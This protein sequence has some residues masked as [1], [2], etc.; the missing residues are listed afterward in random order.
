MGSGFL[1]EMVSAR[2]AAASGWGKLASHQLRRHKRPMRYLIPVSILLVAGCAPTPAPTPSKPATS[3]PLLSNEHEH[4][5]LKGMTAVDLAEHLGT[6]RIQIR[7]GDG[8]KLQFVGATCILDA[9]LYPP[10]EG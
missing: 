3:A 2:L 7:E 4:D 10:V 9:Y 6:P 1:R 8:L 5:S